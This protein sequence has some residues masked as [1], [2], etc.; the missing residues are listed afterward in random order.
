MHNI[1]VIPILYYV[2]VFVTGRLIIATWPRSRWYGR[3]HVSH[4]LRGNQW[5]WRHSV[6]SAVH[7]TPAMNPLWQL[8]VLVIS[9]SAILSIQPIEL[10]LAPAIV[11]RLVCASDWTWSGCP[12]YFFNRT[13]IKCS[14]YIMPAKSLAAVCC[15]AISYRPSFRK[16]RN[17][18]PHLIFCWYILPSFKSKTPKLLL[19]YAVKFSEQNATY[20]AA[21]ICHKSRSKLLFFF[22]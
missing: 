5:W 7:R 1:F 10:H 8:L 4:V 11:I 12:A 6:G 15:A 21:V 2:T 22:C 17:R 18:T 13:T 20:F 19:I 16:Y 9:R 14:G 3:Y